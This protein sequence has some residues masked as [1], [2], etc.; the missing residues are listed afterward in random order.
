MTTQASVVLPGA[1]RRG[2]SGGQLDHPRGS[3]RRKPRARRRRRRGRPR[4]SSRTSPQAF[5]TARAATVVPSCRRRAAAAQAALAPAR[6]GRGACRT[7]APV[8]APTLPTAC[9]PVGGGLAGGV[10]LVRRRGGGPLPA[11]PR[12][13]MQA[14]GTIGTRAAPVSWPRPCS[15]HQRIDAGRGVQAER[16]AAAQHQR[17]HLRHRGQRRQ[18]VGVARRGPAAAHLHAAHRPRR[19]QDHRAAGA[20]GGVGPVADAHPGDLAHHG[21]G[22]GW[23]VGHQYVPRWATRVLHDRRA[24]ARAGLARV[25]VHAQQV[26]H[27]ARLARASRGSCR[28][29][30]RPPRRPRR[31]G[32]GS[33]GAG[34]GSRRRRACPPAARGGSA[35]GR[36][37]RPRTCCPSPA[38]S[39][40]LSSTALTG[41]RRPAS[42]PASTR[43]R[44]A[45]AT[46]A[47]CRPAP[48][49]SAS[50]SCQRRGHDPGPAEAP[51]VAEGD[52]AAVVEVEPGPQEALARPR[53]GRPGRRP[54]VQAAG[55]AQVHGQRVAVESSSTSRYLPRRPTDCDAPPRDLPPRTRRVLGLDQL[56]VVHLDAGDRP[57]REPLGELAPDRLDLRELRHRPSPRPE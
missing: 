38:T 52:R 27:R 11:M 40:W 5:T 43:R 17:G 39:A 26:L 45:A 2:C 9:G 53:R 4:R 1:A 34:G 10:A 36:A 56:G 46:A 6:A 32:R 22:S 44:E 30:R 14:A 24:A 21:A 48:P 29:T 54:P 55:H 37:P 15:S 13:K 16:A 51:H 19:R 31:A 35:P 7:V 28:S 18:Q 50:R 23:Q 12:S 47:R 49:S 3:R 8:P 33:P 41:P 25:Q 42:S 20:G 57:P